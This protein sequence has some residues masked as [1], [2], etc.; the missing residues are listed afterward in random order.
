MNENLL[1][2][3]LMGLKRIKNFIMRKQSSKSSQP[4][5]LSKG[6]TL[7]SN[8]QKLQLNLSPLPWLHGKIVIVLL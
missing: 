4:E 7:V 2:I 3:I 8:S 1:I 6:N 5:I